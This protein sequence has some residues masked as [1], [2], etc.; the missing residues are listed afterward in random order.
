MAALCTPTGVRRLVLDPLDVGEGWLDREPTQNGH[1][2]HLPAAFGEAG[3]LLDGVRSTAESPR[4]LTPVEF[5]MVTGTDR[6]A[7]LDPDPGARPNSSGPSSPN[8]ENHAG[9][10]PEAGRPHCLKSH[11]T[12]DRSGNSRC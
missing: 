11:R 10:E 7:E 5:A 8:A 1:F 2:T 4:V 12:R 3:Y 9:N 6:G